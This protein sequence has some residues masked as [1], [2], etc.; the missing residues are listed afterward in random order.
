METKPEGN[1]MT[2]QRFNT[3]QLGVMGPNRAVRIL[4]LSG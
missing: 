1:Q 3:R 4:T 2:C